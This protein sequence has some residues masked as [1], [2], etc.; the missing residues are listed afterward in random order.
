MRGRE[1]LVIVLLV[2]LAAGT[3]GYLHSRS[4]SSNYI[5][6]SPETLQPVSIGPAQPIAVREAPEIGTAAAESA[7]PPAA[8]P[9]PSKLG[10][11]RH[12][13]R[14]DSFPELLSSLDVRERE[15][16][17]RFNRRNYG[18]LQFQ[19][20]AQFR[21]LQ[22]SGYPLPE[23]FLHAD[24]LSLADLKA[25]ADNADDVSVFLYMD[26]LNDELIQ[27][28][29]EYLSSGQDPERIMEY[30]D[31]AVLHVEAS[32]M[33]RRLLQSE[34]PFAGYLVSRYR[35]AGDNDAYGEI[36]GLY[37]AAARGDIRASRIAE[38]LIADSELP[39]EVGDALG[40]LS[41]LLFNESA[42]ENGYIPISR[43]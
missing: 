25:M 26:R 34:S 32:R 14:A 17:A 7:S 29:Y 21:W 1:W 38:R 27:T 15:E 37:L 43:Q 42:R 28:R 30:R 24:S 18:A 39:P 41:V 23:Q 20:E 35:S 40:A 2:G 12:R 19:S 5:D 22:E 8:A 6:K 9:E 31:F 11:G 33:E 16:L 4:G 13:I 10:A 36:A 3:L